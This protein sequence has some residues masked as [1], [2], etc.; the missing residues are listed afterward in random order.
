MHDRGSGGRQRTQRVRCRRRPRR[1][2]VS[3]R[4]LE[5]AATVGGGTRSA[6]LTLPGLLH[7]ECSGFHPLAIDTPF[8][9]RFDLL[10]HGLSWLWPQVQYSHPLDGGRGAAAYGSVAET[11]AGL[12]VDGRAWRAVF[13]SLAARFDGITADFLRPMVHV[14]THPLLL[15][16][17][18]AYAAMPAAVLARRWSTA[19]A[20]ALFGGV[21]AHAIRPFTSSMSAAIG[22]ALGP[23]R[24][25]TAGRSPRRV[26][27]HRH[28]HA[29]AAQKY[30]GTVEIGVRVES[31]DELGA[32]DI[33]MLDT[34]P[35]AAV[36]LAGN[37]MPRRIAR[38]Y[39]RYRHGPGAFKVDFAVEGGVPW[40]FEPSRRPGRSTCRVI[41]RRRRPSSE[42]CT[43][44][45]CRIRRLCSS[46]N[47][48]SPTTRVRRAT[49]IRCT[50][51]RMYRP[52]TPAMPPR[53][54]PR[55]SSASRRVSA[56]PCVPRTCAARPRCRC[57]IRT[58]SVAT[59]SPAQTRHDSWCFDPEWH[60]TR[61]Q[62]VSPAS[63]CARRLPR[64]GRCA[65]D[66][67]LQCGAVGAAGGRNVT[68]VFPAPEQDLNRELTHARERMNT[69]TDETGPDRPRIG[70][71]PPTISTPAR[72]DTR[73]VT[74]RSAATVGESG[75]CRLGRRSRY[76]DRSISCVIRLR[77]LRDSS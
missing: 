15:A 54:S 6:E 45:R 34:A 16:R 36:R 9:R 23:P 42:R 3:V 14:P 47:S 29:I 59:S 44:A 4:G 75:A 1:E 37:R 27:G 68:G 18:G 32:P 57:T 43:A 70:Q 52:D 62:P 33:V 17:F 71:D 12:G 51:T 40:S 64:R 10:A 53:R 41:S 74:G 63:I 24:M 19:E 65:R 13:G 26:A 39:R 35:E 38:A 55:R 49:C 31:L 67:R 60:L 72:R 21:A 77:W 28:S 11:A 8:S 7:D 22:V 5:A 66:V 46:D 48:S 20:R 76:Q 58:T 56:T 73:M 2:G 69:L 30:G 61:T 50:R 25:P